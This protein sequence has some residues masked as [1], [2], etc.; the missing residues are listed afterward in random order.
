MRPQNALRLAVSIPS[1][2]S[3]ILGLLFVLT[4]EF[5]FRIL[6]HSLK[7]ETLLKTCFLTDKPMLLSIVL[8]AFVL[9]LCPKYAQFKKEMAHETL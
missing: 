3:I 7:N 8:S 1:K 9:L 4:L 2:F 6:G 5:P